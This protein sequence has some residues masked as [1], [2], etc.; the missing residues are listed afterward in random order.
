MENQDR[1]LSANG[2]DGVVGIIPTVNA[3]QLI[4]ESAAI[5]A[6]VKTTKLYELAELEDFTCRCRYLGMS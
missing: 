5:C 1:S 2:H 4:Y 3:Y 6:I